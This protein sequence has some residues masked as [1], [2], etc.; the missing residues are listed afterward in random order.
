VNFGATSA[1]MSG[2]CCQRPAVGSSSQT[3][4]TCTPVG[5][6]AGSEKLSAIS[7]ARGSTA[8]SSAPSMAL[9]AG[10]GAAVRSGEVQLAEGLV[11]RVPGAGAGGCGGHLAEPV[12][13]SALRGRKRRPKT[14]RED[15]GWLRQLLAEGR[16]PESWMPAHQALRDTLERLLEAELVLVGTIRRAELDLRAPQ[17]DVRNPA[18]GG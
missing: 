9:A 8:A 11:V 10:L 7:F 14:D 16:L 1:G 12:E 6:Y 15:A 5:S 17:G 4:V 2:S 18:G 3:S 13:T